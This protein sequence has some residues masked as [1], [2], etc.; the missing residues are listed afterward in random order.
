VST[1]RRVGGSLPVFGSHHPSKGPFFV[2]F[3]NGAVVTICIDIS[4]VFLIYELAV[5]V[6]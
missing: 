4:F 6:H 3:K 1:A 2:G 5:S